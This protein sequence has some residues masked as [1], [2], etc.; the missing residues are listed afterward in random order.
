MF[1]TRIDEVG[2]R[3]GLW[4]VV[5]PAGVNKFQQAMWK[6]ICDGCGRC[7][8]VRGCNLRTHGSKGCG[9][10]RQVARFKQARNKIQR[11]KYAA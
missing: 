3:Y 2:E 8:K 5:A 1:D 6:V 9:S 11:R 10:C 7:R 4:V